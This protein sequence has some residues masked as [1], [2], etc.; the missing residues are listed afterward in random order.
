MEA[1]PPEAIG[2]ER[3]R[4]FDDAAQAYDFQLLEERVNA[5]VAQL[6]AGS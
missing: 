3:W 5:L 1:I 6:D 2:D 4:A